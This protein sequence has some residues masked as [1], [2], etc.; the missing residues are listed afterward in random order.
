M[1]SDQVPVSHKMKQNISIYC[2]LNVLNISKLLYPHCKESISLHRR[3]SYSVL[4]NCYSIDPFYSSIYLIFTYCITC[5]V[6]FDTNITQSTITAK[7]SARS[8]AKRHQRV[9]ECFKRRKKSNRT[10]SR[11]FKR[12]VVLL[13]AHRDY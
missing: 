2:S 8:E 9:Y 3:F 4:H 1:Q 5:H 11:P 10:S 13:G 6:S 7:F 12:Y